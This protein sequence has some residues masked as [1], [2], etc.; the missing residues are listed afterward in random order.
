[1]IALLVT[2]ISLEKVVSPPLEIGAN[3]FQKAT[4]STAA[5]RE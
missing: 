1:M 5:E 4:D 3:V 2:D